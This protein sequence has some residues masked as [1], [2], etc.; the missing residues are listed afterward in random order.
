MSAPRPLRPRSQMDECVYHT[1]R[2]T[3]LI[4]GHPEYCPYYGSRKPGEVP[5]SPPK[6]IARREQGN[7]R[8]RFLGLL[9]RLLGARL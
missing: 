6:P 3:C 2:E 8:N 9:A 4:C 5:V 1:Y 7:P